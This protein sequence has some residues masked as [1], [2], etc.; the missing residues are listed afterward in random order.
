MENFS[1]ADFF[2]QKAYNYLNTM[3]F[4][5]SAGNPVFDSEKAHSILKDNCESIFSE[6][7]NAARESIVRNFGE[8]AHAVEFSLQVQI[9]D[10]EI[11]RYVA[12]IADQ[13]KK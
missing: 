11:L 6:C 7:I 8:R 4:Y 3:C 1:F 13:S 2:A 10:A 12:K 5:N 9:F